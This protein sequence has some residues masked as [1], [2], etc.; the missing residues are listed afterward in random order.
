MAIEVEHYTNLD[1]AEVAAAG[2]LDRAAQPSPYDR[3]E[4]LRLI[5]AHCPPP[6]MPL[7][8]RAREGTAE[9]WLPLMRAGKDAVALARWYSLRVGPAFVG[10]DAT[11]RPALITA[12]AAHLRRL[13]LAAVTLSPMEPD[14]ATLT[15]DAFA[16]AGWHG[17][18]HGATANWQVSTREKDFAGYWAERPGRLRSTAKRK[19]KS[20]AMDIAIHRSFDAEAWDAYEDV[21]R[22]SWKPEEGS[23][24]FVRALAEQEGAAGTVRIGVASKEGRALAAQFWHVEDG[25]ATIHK[26]AHVKDADATSPGTILST[27]MFRH[28]LEQDRPHLI[29]FGT[30]EDA[31][32]AEWMD[33]RRMLL[34]IELLNP[35]S[36]S[37]LVRLARQR[38]AALVRR[39]TID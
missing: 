15:R 5:A 9:A 14:L 4:W 20:A 34:R 32:K 18:T 35:R 39:R 29:D 12:I 19:A 31:Y 37:G 30:G 22:Q 21:Y 33:T 13:G 26:L 38:V 8:V 7:I 16:A 10:D 36:L 2:G 3:I 27:E 17:T 25:I 28:V 24:A 11:R 6:G 1:D 23:P